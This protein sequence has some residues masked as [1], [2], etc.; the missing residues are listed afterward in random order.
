MTRPFNVGLAP[1]QLPQAPPTNLTASGDPS[2]AASLPG[3]RRAVRT[4]SAAAISQPSLSLECPALDRGEVLR[5]RHWSYPQSHHRTRPPA[6]RNRLSHE[7]RARLAE[8]SPRNARKHVSAQPSPARGSPVS[9]ETRLPTFGFSLLAPGFWLLLLAPG[10][11]LLAPGSCSWLLAPGSWLLAPGSW[12]PERRTISP[13]HVK[14][15]LADFRSGP[16]T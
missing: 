7:G 4:S 14:Q 3:H 16:K 6:P 11:W 12:L 15:A 9:R 10:S 2:P 1:S 5:P 13:F 8:N